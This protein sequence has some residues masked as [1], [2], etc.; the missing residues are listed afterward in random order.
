MDSGEVGMSDGG[1]NTAKELRAEIMGKAVRNSP[2]IQ[3]TM[4]VKYH[5]IMQS[6]VEGG[7]AY[8]KRTTPD[9]IEDFSAT[10]RGAFS[11]GVIPPKITTIR[12]LEFLN[13]FIREEFV[14]LA[15]SAMRSKKG[16]KEDRIE[17]LQ[18]TVDDVMETFSD[19]HRLPAT[20]AA[21][22]NAQ[23]LRDILGKLS[24]D[25]RASAEKYMN[26]R[27]TTVDRGE[28]MDKLQKI[29]EDAAAAV[30]AE[31]EGPLDD[32][33]DAEISA[34][35]QNCPCI[36]C[37]AQAATTTFT[38]SST[39]TQVAWEG[40][41]S[42]KD[43]CMNG[44]QLKEDVL[45][46]TLRTVL[47]DTPPP[48]E[49]VQ[50]M[51]ATVMGRTDIATYTEDVHETLAKLVPHINYPKLEELTIA[52]AATAVSPSTHVNKEITPSG[53]VEGP[54]PYKPK[55]KATTLRETLKVDVESMAESICRT[56]D[57]RQL[58][59]NLFSIRN[60]LAS[61]LTR[62]LSKP[63]HNYEGPKLPTEAES[64]SIGT[65]MENPDVELIVQLVHDVVKNFYPWQTKEV[66]RAGAR[67]AMEDYH[68]RREK[69]RGDTAVQEGPKK[70]T[71]GKQPPCCELGLVADLVY[72]AASPHLPSLT[73]E[74]AQ[75]ITI[76]T[77]ADMEKAKKRKRKAKPKTKKP[78][79]TAT[80]PAE[81]QGSGELA[82][83]VTD[84]FI[85][86][87][88]GRKQSPHGRKGPTTQHMEGSTSPPIAT[89]EVSEKPK[90]RFESQV[91]NETAKSPAINTACLI[92]K[93]GKLYYKRHGYIDVKKK[94]D[95]N[96]QYLFV[97]SAHAGEL[98][99]GVHSMVFYPTD[100]HLA[101][102]VKLV[103][104]LHQDS[105]P[106]GDSRVYELTPVNDY[107]SWVL[108]NMKPAK[109]TIPTTDPDRS[110]ITMA[111]FQIANLEATVPL[112]GS[113]KINS[114]SVIGTDRDTAAPH[115]V[116]KVYVLVNTDYGDCRAPYYNSK[117][118]I[119]GAHRWGKEICEGMECNAGEVDYPCSYVPARH[120]WRQHVNLDE[121][122][123]IQ[124]GKGNKTRQ[125]SALASPDGDWSGDFDTHPALAGTTM[126]DLGREQPKRQPK[127]A[128]WWKR[129]KNSMLH[130]K[131]PGGESTFMVGKPS[132]E[133]LYKEVN[134][135]GLPVK[136][137][138]I[139]DSLLRAAFNKAAR[140]DAFSMVTAPGLD[141][142][143][144]MYQCVRHLNSNSQVG[145]LS[146]RGRRGVV[147]GNRS[148]GQHDF[149]TKIG[150]MCKDEA[151]QLHGMNSFDPTHL[152]AGVLADVSLKLLQ[153]IIEDPLGVAQNIRWGVEGKTDTYSRAKIAKGGGRSIQAPPVDFKLVHLY[154]FMQSD[155][156]WSANT[157]SPYYITYNPI[158]KM[159]DRLLH[160]MQN[161]VGA[162]ATDVSGW[163]RN[164]CA[165]VIELYFDVYLAQLCVGIPSEVTRYMKAATIYSVL[166]LPDGQLLM[167]FRA[168]PSGHPNTIRLNSVIQRVVN[169]CCMA[170]AAVEHALIPGVDDP[171]FA[172]A[173]LDGHVRSFYCGDD[174]IN[175]AQTEEGFQ[176]CELALEQWETKTPWTVKLEGKV[177]YHLDG[178]NFHC[179]PNFVSRVPRRLTENGT[180]WYHVLCKPDKILAKL[181]HEPKR[182]TLITRLERMDGIAGALPH[183]IVACTSEFP[184]P[185]WQADMEWYEWYV[186]EIEGTTPLTVQAMRDGAARLLLRYQ[187]R[188]EGPGADPSVAE[189]TAAAHNVASKPLPKRRTKTQAAQVRNKDKRRLASVLPN[190]PPLL[191]GL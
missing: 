25:V 56:M 51:R 23:A 100:Q 104:S 7:Y 114:G 161:A 178:S 160:A 176:L 152:G 12:A 75:E 86:V 112:K 10:E 28:V 175:F 187:P 45:M 35:L 129:T 143:N 74:G 31:L 64:R 76:R 191:G 186:R 83:I 24:I 1:S 181:Y 53:R 164:M 96:N 59:N 79:A 58:T 162:V 60:Q 22:E 50:Q 44:T 21:R 185:G 142:Y 88:K 138:E 98:K 6:I 190:H 33:D 172:L 116:R 118:Q 134:K 128:N 18:D 29:A 32:L 89:A 184:A 97:T 99:E 81:P 4:Q 163:D 102:E 17:E 87:M 47:P 61:K 57:N 71:R 180:T 19:K 150:D 54:A 106:S 121:F 16:R 103:G 80:K 40:P 30:S 140:N 37:T 147:H 72:S 65:D 94:D 157:E 14:Q 182:E 139:P 151:G 95:V 20:K 27:L 173:H 169:E 149:L 63:P 153:D 117:G 34:V 155:A 52:R 42:S 70:T 84:G 122:R 69:L 158:E 5:A 66:L 43:Q 148:E 9:I 131:I 124:G 62:H 107:G 48:R 109:L 120:D 133:A 49:L 41:S 3:H 91:I 77:I 111:C 101:M 46:E 85:K 108:R 11:K 159:Q 39:A 38:K 110:E 145:R 154:Y 113:W 177:R 179:T 188:W 136:S 174:G 146:V 189:L 73:L 13:N 125:E 67:L 135:M 115:R 123:R 36:A 166:S 137:L 168:N 127:G 8:L 144:H 126:F 141:D 55:S 15:T 93:K 2:H 132:D 156:Q 119:V 183:G 130:N 68:L 105:Q 26:M 78:Q 170:M 171:I 92:T 167:K 82:T 90:V 165:R